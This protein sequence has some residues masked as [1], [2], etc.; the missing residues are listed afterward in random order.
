MIADRLPNAELEV[1]D[2]SGHYVHMD[3]PQE[4]AQVVT[5]FL[6]EETRP[7]ASTTG[8]S[9]NYIRKSA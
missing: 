5:R 6:G 4:L 9:E 8:L 7:Q 3:K 1:I 2:K